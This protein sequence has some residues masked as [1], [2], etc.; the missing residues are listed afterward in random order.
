MTIDIRRTWPRD[1]EL[2]PGA[3][4]GRAAVAV[5]GSGEAEYPRCVKHDI[6]A[7]RAADPYD[8]ADDTAYSFHGVVWRR[9]PIG[10]GL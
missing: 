9:R 10:G 5:G 1:P 3:L 6:R 7:V 8:P 2:R 4:C